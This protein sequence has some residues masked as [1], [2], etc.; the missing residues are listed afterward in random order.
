MTRIAI[1]NTNGLPWGGCDPIWVEAAHTALSKGHKILLSTNKFSEKH[2]EI[3]HLENKGA[4][5]F[6]RRNYNTRILIRIVKNILNAFRLKDTVIPT[7]RHIHKFKP[8]VIF[9][10]LAGGFEFVG[11]KALFNLI[12]KSKVPVYLMVHSYDENYIPDL[13]AIKILNHGFNKAK[14]VFFTSRYQLEG[15][16]Y[17]IMYSENN[18]KVIGNPINVEPAI[19]DYPKNEILNFGLPGNLSAHWKGQDIAI[20][21]LAET[22]WKNRK[23][24]LNIYGNGTDEWYLKKLVD[25][26][27]LQDRVI[28]HGYINDIKTIWKHNHIALLPSRQDSGPLTAI[29]AIAC[30]RTIIGTHIGLMADLIDVNCG[31]I[32]DAATLNS[33]R[34]TLEQ[35]WLQNTRWKEMGEKAFVRYQQLYQPLRNKK[36]IDFLITP[37]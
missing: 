17:K 13:N 16:S 21:L 20:H 1:V 7:F 14:K 30:G 25:Q 4:Q 28:F 15:I 5:V 8:S 36:L 6:F 26:Y 22:Q 34:K 12:I 32:S 27:H 10:N 19:M 23:W 11:D 9:I 31:F 18:F 2:H 24:Q 3:T 35:A 37:I 33:F 29:E